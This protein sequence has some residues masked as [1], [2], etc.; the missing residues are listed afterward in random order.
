MKC[1]PHH[2][3]PIGNAVHDYF[4]TAKSCDILVESD[5]AE[6][7]TIP[8]SYFFRKQEEMPKLELSA[9][10]LCRGKTLDVGAA[11]GCHAIFLQENGIDV[12]ALEISELCCNIMEKRGISQVIQSDY[13]EY[14]GVAYDTLLFLMNGIGLA[15][16][17]E[18]LPKFLR[19]AGELLKPGGQ[20]L[21]DSS[22]IDYMYYEDD[23]S[24]L[25]NLNSRYYGEIMYRMVYK[26]I[27]GEP[28]PWLF[29]DFQTLSTLAIKCGFEARL[30]EKGN[31][32]DYLACL[33]KIV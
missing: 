28:F 20:M 33:R 22:D 13:F 21:F 17:L 23:G 29:I 3:D 26:N 2:I 27:E 7:S 30:I 4:E 14:S 24:K 25:I 10:A 31:Q 15:G 5:I 8:S 6:I 11:A 9:L 16:T 1:I 32:H 12:S 18:E 19:K